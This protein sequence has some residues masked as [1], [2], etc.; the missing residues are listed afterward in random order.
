[1]LGYK[2]VSARAS[3]STQKRPRARDTRKWT[4]VAGVEDFKVEGVVSFE[5]LTPQEYASQKQKQE[6]KARPAESEA[7]AATPRAPAERKAGPVDQAAPAGPPAKK[8]RRSEKRKKAKLAKQAKKP[9][10]EAAIEAADGEGR[11][12][13]AAPRLNA[14]AAHACL[15]R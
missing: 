5:E 14:D 15:R 13:V 9:E 7:A 1:M 2:G 10:P 12:G 6:K 11:G 4:P 3:M 8:R